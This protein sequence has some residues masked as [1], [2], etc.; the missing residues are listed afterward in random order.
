LE[1][2]FPTEPPDALAV[3]PKALL[4]LASPLAFAVFP[5]AVFELPLP[6][7]L[8]LVPQATLVVLPAADAPAPLAVA[9]GTVAPLVAHADELR[10]RL[11]RAERQ[12][13][14]QRCAC[15]RNQRQAN[16]AHERPSLEVVKVLT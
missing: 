9:G 3:F 4:V 1:L 8:A 2:L 14:C 13:E 12:H 16:V 7:A 5:T 11:R 6:F 15:R 10:L